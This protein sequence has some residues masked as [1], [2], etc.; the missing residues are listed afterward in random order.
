MCMCLL[1]FWLMLGRSFKMYENWFKI[2]T[3]DSS[4][5]LEN[6]EGGEVVCRNESL[7]L[8][9]LHLTVE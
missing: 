4:Q 7:V 3:T 1:K 2:V 8:K 6:M 5:G 9:L